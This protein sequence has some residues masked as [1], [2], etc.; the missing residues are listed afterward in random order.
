M[1]ANSAL[2][3]VGAMRIASGFLAA[4]AF[5]IGVCK[6]ASNWSGPWKL[7]LTPFFLASALAPQFIVMEKSSP[8]TPAIRARSF[9]PPP[10][11]LLPQAA[12]AV[13]APT[14]ATAAI[15]LR[16]STPPLLVDLT[17]P[18]AAGHD[19]A[20]RDRRR[21]SAPLPQRLAARRAALRR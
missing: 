13:A 6:D 5:T 14:A 9:L 1:G 21:R 12:S 4:T 10:P 18:A 19:G 16:I 11:P 3:S 15:A 17:I 7:R 8:L 20:D 2:V